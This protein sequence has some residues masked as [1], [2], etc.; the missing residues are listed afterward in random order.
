L[1]QV[2]SRSVEFVVGGAPSVECSW[3]GVKWAA[4]QSINK[5]SAMRMFLP[6]I[7]GRDVLP[8][9]NHHGCEQQSCRVR[10]ADG[11]VV[12]QTRPRNFGFENVAP[13]VHVGG[14]EIWAQVLE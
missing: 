1:F 11:S 10:T 5:S 9:E 13:K 14:E 4:L 8:L 2:I 3:G 12:Q 6:Y 7:S